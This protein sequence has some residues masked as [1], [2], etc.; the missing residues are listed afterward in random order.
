MTTYRLENS[1]VL[2]V[3]NYNQTHIHCFERSGGY[4]ANSQDSSLVTVLDDSIRIAAIDGVTPTVRTRRVHGTD[5]AVWAAGVAR[6][7]LAGSPEKLASVAHAINEVLFDDS[8]SNSR[9]QQQVALVAAD[10]P[11]ASDSES[12]IVILRAADCVAWAKA[13]GQWRRIFEEDVHIPDVRKAIDAWLTQAEQIHG[14][15]RYAMEEVL[16]GSPEHWLTTALGRFRTPRLQETAVNGATE[17]LLA[18]DGAVI[19]P[20]DPAGALTT[21]PEKGPD[22]TICYIA[23]S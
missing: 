1:V 3:H 21:Q 7:L 12:P 20:E 13:N 22:C 15:P 11:L 6:T 19:P 18:T 23:V 4:A 8:V 10:I 14:E 16:S 2:Q 17:L 5:G 9:D